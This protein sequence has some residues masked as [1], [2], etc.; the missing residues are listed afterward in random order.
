MVFFS[1]FMKQLFPFVRKNKSQKVS[2]SL[3]QELEGA[4][5][6]RQNLPTHRITY[7]FIP[8]AKLKDFDILRLFAEELNVPIPIVRTDLAALTKGM[9]HKLTICI[10]YPY[11]EEFYRD[12]YYSFYARKHASYNRFCFRL[13]FFKEDVSEANFYDIDLKDK[14]YGYVTLRPTPKRVVGYTFLNPSI[15][16]E[17]NFSICL[18]ERASFVKGRKVVTTAFPFSGQDGEMT[19]C[20]ETAATMLL[21]Y[22]SRRY[23]KYSRLLPSQIAGQLSNNVVDRKQPSVGVDV[24][25]MASVMNTFGVNTRQYYV[26]EDDDMEVRQYTYPK[27]EFNRLLHVYVESGIPI[28]LA[29]RTHAK[30]VIGRQNKLFAHG[31]KMIV[32]DD[33]KRP[34]TILENTDDVIS[35]VVPMP[36]NILLDIDDLKPYEEIKTLSGDYPAAKISINESNERPYNQRIFLTTSR[37]YKSYIVKSNLNPE[38]RDAIMSI[39]MPKF[40]WVC[41]SFK[42][43]AVKK[44]SQIALTNVAIFDATDYSS[45]YD[46]ILMLKSSEKLVIPSDNKVLLKQKSFCVLDAMDILHPFN[47]NLKGED[48]NWKC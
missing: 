16:S 24:D 40:V 18:C 6:Y 15:Y 11:V 30:I 38:V 42:G 5:E 46:N 3:L 10:E 19:T 20:A 39:C 28:Y 22:F 12:T 32:M 43:N 47:N 34:Y 25:T 7:R 23:N 27:E 29:T 41:E 37:S 1:F 9:I 8:Y 45:N 35:F 13:S 17:H 26:K 2:A 14:Y 33:N 48:V 31:A 4:P 21:D 44:T 36:D